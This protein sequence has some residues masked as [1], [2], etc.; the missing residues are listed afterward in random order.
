[1]VG[2]VI[3]TVVQR[4][5]GAVAAEDGMSTAEYSV[6]WDYFPGVL[7]RSSPTS[8]D[9]QRGASSTVPVAGN[10]APRSGGVPL[11]P[12]SSGAVRPDGRRATSAGPTR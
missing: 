12:G 9:N 7:R 11:P 2:N 4:L 1:M 10:G 3:R 8:D 6:V 5:S